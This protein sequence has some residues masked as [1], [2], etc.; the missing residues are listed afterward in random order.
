M[1]NLR[2][3]MNKQ[4]VTVGAGVA[5]IVAGI[6]VLNGAISELRVWTGGLLFIFGL[7][8]CVYGMESNSS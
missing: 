5:L 4:L 8:T 6:A 3:N 7:M 2:R 1:E